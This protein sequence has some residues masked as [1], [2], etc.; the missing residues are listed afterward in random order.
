M[1]HFL[2]RSIPFPLNH[3]AGQFFLTKICVLTL[4]L[5]KYLSRHYKLNTG[6]FSRFSYFILITQLHP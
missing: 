4:Y 1:F 2:L 6:H 3:N 5:E